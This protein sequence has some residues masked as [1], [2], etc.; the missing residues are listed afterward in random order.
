VSYRDGPTASVSVVEDAGGALRLRIDNRQD[1]GSSATLVADARQALLPL[2]L[3]P[4]PRHALFLG[5][6]TGVT[7]TSATLDP[8]LRVDAVEL[9]AEV[10]E[11]STPFRRAVDGDGAS[12]RLH[13]VA[14]DA[15]RFV[16]VAQQ[17]YDVIV[18]DN[19]HP[20]RRGSGSLY[21]VEHFEAVRERL[22]PGGLFCQWLPLHQ[23]D[24][25]TLRSIVR[26]F[27]AVYPGSRAILA[28]NS[29]ETPVVGLVARADGGPFDAA[30]LHRR[31]AVLSKPA[32]LARFGLHD[33]FA[34]LGSFIAGPAALTRF[35]GGA[36]L[37]PDDRPVVA[38]A[39]PRATYAPD[40]RPRDRL[41]ALLGEVEIDAG[42]L[43]PGAE[44]PWQRRLAS[45]WDARD[46]FIHAG[47][48]VRPT[49]DV[50]RM[51]AQVRAPLLEVLQVSPD[52]RPAYDPLLRMALALA[53]V[54]AQAARALLA[55]LQA[56]QPARAEAGQALAALGTALPAH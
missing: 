52:F 9:L 7:A 40:S 36:P 26:T 13:V 37:N 53:T 42:E 34:V 4:A 44:A 20:S 3:H 54:D 50:E 41:I 48:E 49:R 55:E 14:A 17:P 28:T 33:D 16:R 43:V 38:S 31:I 30:L 10:V 5:L 22:A 2:L 39:A 24:L 35:A 21:T 18:S 25:G 45:Y 46:R 51:L 12:A 6:G 29:L 8:T 23:L 32:D 47:R 27:V 15:R 19:F 56:V 11:A 1:E